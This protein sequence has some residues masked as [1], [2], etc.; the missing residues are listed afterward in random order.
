MLDRDLTNDWKTLLQKEKRENILLKSEQNWS[1]KIIAI[2][3]IPSYTRNV[4]V[5]H[6]KKECIDDMDICCVGCSH[7]KIRQLFGILWAEVPVRRSVMTRPWMQIGR[8][9]W[10]RNDLRSILERSPARLQKLASDWYERS[11]ATS[12]LRAQMQSFQ[13]SASVETLHNHFDQ[14]CVI[15]NESVLTSQKIL[16]LSCSR[17]HHTFTFIKASV[18]AN[19]FKHALT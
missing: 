7:K 6:V 8:R 2:S 18:L 15:R 9:K 14:N 16:I 3:N 19:T 11:A 4:H 13:A 17:T 5:H 10:I 1:R 12:F